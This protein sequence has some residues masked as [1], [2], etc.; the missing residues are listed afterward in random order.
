MTV[1]NPQPVTPDQV[2]VENGK[3]VNEPQDT[4]EHEIKPKFEIAESEPL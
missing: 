2:P 1:R 3:E 4:S